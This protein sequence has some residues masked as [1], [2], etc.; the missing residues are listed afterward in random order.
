M[1]QVEACE[2]PPGALL[3]QYDVPPG[4]T[5]CFSVVVSGEVDF[6]RYVVAFYTT[7]LFRLERWILRFIAGKPS[8]DEDIA[9]L[10]NGDRTSFAAWHLEA[11]DD[12][13]ILLSDY[14]GRTRSWLMSDLSPG[15]TTRLYFG[16]AIVA[17][18]DPMSGEPRL[19]R[20]F[21]VLLGLHRLYSVL[22]LSSARRR[23]NR[24]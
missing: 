11:Q 24:K 6:Y 9:E 10:V 2:L 19:G 12:N 22:L 14:V 3:A 8:R 1:H 20:L 13:Q 23:L 18:T 4:Y 17:E 16:S 5:D 21:R 7:P 15:G